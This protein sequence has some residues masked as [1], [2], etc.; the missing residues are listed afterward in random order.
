MT[1][2]ST[3]SKAGTW[4]TVDRDGYTGRYQVAISKTD[5]N[6]YGHGHRLAGPKY[7]GSGENVIEERLSAYDAAGIME[8][9]FRCSTSG[10][11]AV[12][13]RASPSTAPVGRGESSRVTAATRPSGGSW[14][15]ASDR[16]DPPSPRSTIT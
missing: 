1:T 6:G 11:A 7:S 4:I 5:E 14:G 10:R 3:E 9:A 13:T 16:P 2:T 12:K 8:Y 15:W